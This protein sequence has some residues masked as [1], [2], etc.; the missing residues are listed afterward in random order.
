MAFRKEADEAQIT[1]KKTTDLLPDAARFDGPYSADG[2]SRPLCLPSEFAE[3]N[4][5]SPA[6]KTAL[7]RFQADGILWHRGTNGGPTTHL[8]SSQVQCVNAL[9]PFLL[10]PEGLSR[11]LRPILPI[12]EMLP[13]ENG[14]Q[15]SDLVVFE[16]VGREDYLGEAAGRPRYRGAHFTSADAAVRY[17]NTRDEIEIALLEWKYAERYSCGP[18]SGGETSL[19]KRQSTYRRWWSDEGP[20]RLDV[21]TYADIF[22]EPLYQLFRLQCLALEME[23]HHEQ[24]AE[25]VRLVVAAPGRNS[26]FWNAVPRAYRGTY[27]DLAALWHHL[28]RQ[29]DRFDIL[30]TATL[31]G[32]HGTGVTAF[33]HRY[34][35]LSSS[36]T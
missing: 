23:R 28:Q 27:P 17:R 4:L 31:V 20:I 15:S 24:G 36:P 21:L 34:A 2:P 22:T 35:H 5:L 18:L 16:W 9:A 29:P 26:G 13:F 10:D 7:S 12:A 32:E 25:R 8:C 3:L 30:D 1:W 14:P 33:R 6:R 19:L 11:M